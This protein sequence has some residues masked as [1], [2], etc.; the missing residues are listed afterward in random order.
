M[1]SR[2]PNSIEQDEAE[3]IHVCDIFVPEKLH[4]S[5]QMLAAGFASRKI[6]LDFRHLE[7]LPLLDKTRE[8]VDYG[9]MLENR[10]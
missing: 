4:D 2:L 3:F 8:L 6:L 9:D 1:R 5:S 7:Q 10:T